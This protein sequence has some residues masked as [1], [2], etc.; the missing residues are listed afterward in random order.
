MMTDE[1][2]VKSIY[3]KAEIQCSGFDAYP[4]RVVTEPTL[5]GKWLGKKFNKNDH[6]KWKNAAEYLREQM[7]TKLE[8]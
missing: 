2:F 4:S 3:P 5:N 1:Q 7:I 6:N 8:E